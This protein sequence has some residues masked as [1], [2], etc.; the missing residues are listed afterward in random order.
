MTRAT[1]SPGAAMPA[2]DGEGGRLVQG[3]RTNGGAGIRF[4][5]SGWRG[6]LGEDVRF[7]ALRAVTAA[8]ATW[9]RDRSPHTAVLVGYDTRFASRTMAEITAEILAAGGLRPSLS[10]GVVPTPVLTHAVLRRRVAGGLML[11]ASHN[12]AEYHGLKV[13]GASGCNLADA[14]A[15]LIEAGAASRPRVPPASGGR[16]RRIELVAGYRRALLSLIDRDR[17]AHSKLRVLYDAMHGAGAGVLDAV[18]D[19]A[20]LRVTTLRGARDPNFGGEAPDPTPSRLAELSQR[21]ARPRGA[22]VGLATDGDADRF[23]VVLPGGRV[24]SE[25]EV[26]ALLVDH[27]ART[28]RA[29]RG[30]AISCCT[31][32][33]VEKVAA[34]HGLP[35]AR[36]PV[37]F[38]HL[39]VQLESGSADVAGEESGGFAYAA[40]SR[41]KDG[42]LAGALIC[43]IAAGER[44]GLRAALH[45]LE[46]RHGRSA[47]GRQA[48]PWS[49]E[50]AAALG[51]LHAAPPDRVGDATVRAVDPRDGLRLTLD[52]GFVMLRRSGTEPVIRLYAEAAGP[53]R[54]ARRIRQ[55]E[56]LLRSARAREG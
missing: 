18:L 1:A 4:G 53:R 2:G 49:D 25:T 39:A 28:G 12:P 44:G 51:R 20:G 34:E 26:I 29:K 30:V 14:D 22:Q 36:T 56:A 21:M 24:L 17:L 15:R 52:D 33:L 35:L 47:C 7:D 31:G 3:G 50:L 16:I 40:L 55:V 32:S 9:L 45:R 23:G 27:L 11:T 19:E 37:G 5:T 54:L 8:T 48:L 43:E 41:D 38:K 46:S 10:R 6:V 42:I 13:F